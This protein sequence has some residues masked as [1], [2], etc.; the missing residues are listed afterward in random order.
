MTIAHPLALVVG[1]V[2]AVAF[3][4]L[5]RRALRAADASAL[6]YSEL[7]FFERA[8]RQRIDPAHVLTAM[9]ALGIVVLASAFAGV[10][11]VTSVPVGGAVVLCV[12]TSGSMRSTDVTPSRSAAAAA[13][14]RDFIDGAADGT[15]IGIVAFSSAA[16]VVVPLSSDRDAVRQAVGQIPPPN[17]GTAIGDALVAAARMMPPS[18]HRAIVLVTDGVNNLGVDPLT[19]ARQIGASGIEIDT[20]GIGT[21]DSGQFV[22]GTAEPATIDEEELRAVAGSAGGAY[23]RTNDS[24]SLRA[25]LAALS[26]S[27]TTER[28]RID[29]SLPLAVAGGVLVMLALGGALVAGRFP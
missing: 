2:V 13:A 27:T 14:A 15:R 6:A 8:A 18:G 20:V 1:L 7:A 12:D 19:A 23:A 29:A 4:L 25:R 21:N 10:R 16:G 5:G 28:R 22:P 26:K 24:G 11:V 3:L 9:T 17:G